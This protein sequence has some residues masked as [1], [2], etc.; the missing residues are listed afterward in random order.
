M[1]LAKK[2]GK[3]A[4][5]FF[6]KEVSQQVVKEHNLKGAHQASKIIG[7]L[8]KNMSEIEKSPYFR[9]AEQD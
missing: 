1:T 5:S 6:Q 9:Y 4:Y 8:W 3:P 7:Q 2:K